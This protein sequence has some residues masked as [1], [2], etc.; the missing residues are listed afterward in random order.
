MIWD[1]YYIY[2]YLLGRPD[3]VHN[4]S[5]ANHSTDAFFLQC[6]EGF[7][8][9]LPQYFVLDL[10]EIHSQRLRTNVT[11]SIPAFSVTSLEPGS[12]FIAH[13]YAVNNK[14]RSELTPVPVFTMR[15][16]EKILTREKRKMFSFIYYVTRFI[17][18]NLKEE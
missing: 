5:V 12:S 11:S 6:N 1:V 3:S 16:P 8:G 9:G 18:Y 2:I 10:Y 7:N 4:C 15:L 17:N 14:G 13:V